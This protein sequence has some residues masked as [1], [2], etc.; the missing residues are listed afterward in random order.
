MRIKLGSFE[1]EGSEAEFAE[2]LRVSEEL[3][4]AFKV[5]LPKT[6]LMGEKK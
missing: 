6:I 3:Q 4:R 2:L 5:A 1:F